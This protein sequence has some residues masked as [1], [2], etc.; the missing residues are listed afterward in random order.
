MA[1]T[2]H[3]SVR[4]IRRRIRRMVREGAITAI[5][6]TDYRAIKNDIFA[7]AMVEYED[8]ERRTDVDKDLYGTLAGHLWVNGLGDSYI[9]FFLN[10]PNIPSADEV[11]ET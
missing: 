9:V 3:T 6:L 11:L 1:G 10:L 2:L 5:V 8:P 4:T 7:Y